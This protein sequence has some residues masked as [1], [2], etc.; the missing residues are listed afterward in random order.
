LQIAEYFIAHKDGIGIDFVYVPFLI[1]S[2][3]QITWLWF[4]DNHL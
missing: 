4:L 2:A 1:S 3:F